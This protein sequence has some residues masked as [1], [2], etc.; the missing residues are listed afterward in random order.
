MCFP[1]LRTLHASTARIINFPGLIEES[2]QIYATHIPHPA[3]V[4]AIIVSVLQ[5]TVLD[6]LVLYWTTNDALTCICRAALRFM[7]L[8]RAAGG[9]GRILTNGGLTADPAHGGS[10]AAASPQARAQARPNPACPAFAPQRVTWKVRCSA[11]VYYGPPAGSS[12]TWWVRAGRLTLLYNSSHPT[13]TWGGRLRRNVFCSALAAHTS[14]QWAL[15]LLF[16]RSLHRKRC[17]PYVRQLNE[18]M[19]A[20]SLQYDSRCNW[21]SSMY[22]GKCVVTC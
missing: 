1:E 21:A 2:A 4:M 19:L 13:R 16:Q 9:G 18:V 3:L 6:S 5:S 17:L 10:A 8:Y 7:L 11:F 14:L 15:A 12:V 20:Q 22:E